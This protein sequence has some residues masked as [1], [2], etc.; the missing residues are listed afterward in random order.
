M[1]KRSTSGVDVRG[2]RV[3]VRVDFNVPIED[4]QVQDDARIQAHAD[5]VRDLGLRG[6]RV[7][8]ISH[9]GR[10]KGRPIPSLSLRLVADRLATVLGA[11]VAFSDAT[12]GPV[13]ARAVEQVTDGDVLLLEN[14]RFAPGEEANDPVFA[15]ALADLADLY[16][17]DAFGAAHRAHA[18]TVGVA[19]LLPAYAGP[20]LLREVSTLTT[21]LDR[22]R[23]PFVA[24][25]GGAKVSDKLGVMANLVGR[26][27][28]ILVGG[29]MANTLLLST[30]NEIGQSLAEADLVDRARV[31]LDDAA[32]SGT[33]VL[34]PED[35]IVAPGIDAEVG[36]ATKAATVPGDEAIF[37]IGPRTASRYAGIIAGAAT[38]FWNG[39]MG[40]AE[41]P[42]FAGGTLAVA[43]A[44]SASDGTTVVGGGDSIAALRRAGLLHRITHVSTGGGASLELLEGRRLPGVEAI[45]DDG[46]AD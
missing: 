22:P 18:S 5:T 23:H 20:L 28:T 29:G 43:N 15:A 37:D 34:V 4:G 25:L 6:A 39:P 42:P 10:P 36:K 45:P 1:G 2:K 35:V 26:V 32:A 17:D 7:V 12:T 3:L 9:L 24:I 13:A 16:I 41:R 38:V 19:G 44:V 21:L 11:P 14:L 46:A 30:G 33:T 27:D 40:V 31:F 8:L